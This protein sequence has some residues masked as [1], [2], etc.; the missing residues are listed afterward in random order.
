MGEAAVRCITHRVFFFRIRKDTFDRFFALLVKVGVL[1]SIPGIIGKL[2]VVLPNM[3]LYDLYTI[4]GMRA[5]MPCRTVLAYLGMALVFSV[6]VSVGRTVFERMELRAND[7]IKVLVINVFPPFMPA[8][9]GHRSLVC[10][11]ENS[12]VIKYFLANMGRFVCAVCYN[13][14]Y[15]GELFSYFVIY[16]VECYAIVY[17]AGSYYGFKNIAVFVTSGVGFVCKLSFMVALYE[18][19]AVGIGYTFSDSLHLLA[20]G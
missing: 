18:K 9:H 7:A 17:V 14:L 20:A 4:L 15:F 3:S 12:F 19:S 10:R 13:G 6:S 16:I 11:A 1:G 8:V 2:L 5:K